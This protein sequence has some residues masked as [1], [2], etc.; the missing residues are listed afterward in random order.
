MKLQLRRL[1]LLTGTSGSEES[2]AHVA[3]LAATYVHLHPGEDN[4]VKALANYRMPVSNL[5]PP[6]QAFVNIGG[7]LPK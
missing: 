3:A 5:I 1:G 7:V 4:V 6:S 2:S